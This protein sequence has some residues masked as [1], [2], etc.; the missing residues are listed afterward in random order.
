VS[1]P[2]AYTDEE[3]IERLRDLYQKHGYLSGLIINETE[4][5]P[6]AAVYAHRFDSLIR[7]YK[8]VGYTPDR[9]YRYLEVNRLLRQ[10]HP[11][12][13]AQAEIEIGRIGGSV[14][15]DPDQRPAVYQ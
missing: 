11:Q 13:V 5:M 7:A 10:L 2:G 12:V 14:F 9:D 1:A 3:L 4:S 15:R 8:M 6:S